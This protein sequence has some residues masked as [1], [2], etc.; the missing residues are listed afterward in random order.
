MTNVVLLLCWL[1][2]DQ[3]K[4]QSL[5]AG[6]KVLECYIVPNSL[7]SHMQ[8]YFVLFLVVAKKLAKGIPE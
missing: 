7:F 1:G 8:I 3:I 2:L 4:F 6:E 5:L